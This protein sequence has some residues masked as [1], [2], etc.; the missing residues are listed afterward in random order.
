MDRYFIGSHY[1]NPGII[2][3]YLVRIP[4]FLD[5][6]IKFQSG[7]LDCADR[8]YSSMA[9]SYLLALTE[10][11]DVRE[12][13]P[14]T[15]TLPEM[16]RNNLNVNFGVTQENN[17]VDHVE[18]PEWAN[19][20]PYYFTCK[21]KE[22]FES[23]KV[24]ENIHKWFDL[25]F[26]FKQRGDAAVEAVNLY[27]S[28]TY[29]DGIDMNNPEN[30]AIRN[31]LIVQAYNYGQ[32]PTQLFT[33]P[34]VRKDPSKA[35]LIFLDKAADLQS[36]SFDITKKKY[37]IITSGKFINDQDF[38]MFGQKKMLFGMTYLPYTEGS[39]KETLSERANFKKQKIVFDDNKIFMNEETPIKF[40]VKHDLQMIIGGYWD[41]KLLIQNFTKK[42]E[43]AKK[44]HLYRITMIEVSES[45]EVIITGTEKGDIVKWTLDDNNMIYD[46]PFFHHQNSVTGACIQEDM[47]I[48][49][50]C[51]K[52]ATVNLYTISPPYILRSFKQPD[53]YPLSRVLISEA[54]LASII[55]CK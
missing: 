16:Y 42:Q 32:C 14:E 9:H 10:A 43:F 38:V 25:V 48:F 36:K 28:I 3:Q 41:G 17:R 22:I 31:S 47:G 55:M 2:L 23:D 44:K 11:G 18:L 21:M 54:P 34:H 35:P 40:L 20:D 6:L 33:E 37:G 46:R 4:P 26:G 12:L 45:E 52:D 15:T 19:G 39:K 13:I 7:K 24:S 5:G 30:V 27:P 51:S 1:S 53:G 8:M 49:A 50:T 29:E